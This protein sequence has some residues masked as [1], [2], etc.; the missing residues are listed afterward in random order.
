MLERIEL[1]SVE[2]V[3]RNGEKS[4]ASCGE[5]RPHPGGRWA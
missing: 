2:G 3:S 1:R 5:V 4:Q